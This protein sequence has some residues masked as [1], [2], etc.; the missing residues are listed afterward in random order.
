MH[1]VHQC[2][3]FRNTN[4]CMCAHTSESISNWQCFRLT[5]QTTVSENDEPNSVMT[6]LCVSVCVFA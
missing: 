1:Y 2:H 3:N 4:V 6:V 5:E